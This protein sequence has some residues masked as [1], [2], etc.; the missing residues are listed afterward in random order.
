MLAGALLVLCAAALVAFNISDDRAAGAAAQRVLGQ[1]R[2]QMPDGGG[3]TGARG[4]AAEPLVTVEAEGRSYLGVLEIP[5]LELRLPIL[6]KWSYP[7]LKTAPCRYGGSAGAGDL[8]IAG[9]NYKSHF[10]RLETLQA[11]DAVTFT[12]AD[13]GR[14]TYQ[15]LETEILDGSAVAGMSAGDWDLTL[16]TCTVGGARRVTVRCGLVG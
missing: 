16:F 11:G 1:V 9:H 7:G 4:T 12:D 10:G 3:E 8:I 14:Y 13:G 2:A 6:G 5:A 15:V